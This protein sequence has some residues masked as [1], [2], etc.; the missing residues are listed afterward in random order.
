VPEKLE[1]AVLKAMEKDP[2]KR[3]QSVGDLWTD[4]EGNAGE[5]GPS[6]DS[7]SQKPVPTKGKFLDGLVKHFKK[8]S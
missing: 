7:S 3:Q 2:K 1:K 4:I 5:N 6:S 8:S